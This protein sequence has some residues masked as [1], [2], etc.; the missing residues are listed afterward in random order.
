MIKISSILIFDTFVQL[1]FVLDSGHEILTEL[2]RLHVAV[3]EID[4]AES[5]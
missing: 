3:V 4:L 2:D 5:A 1:G